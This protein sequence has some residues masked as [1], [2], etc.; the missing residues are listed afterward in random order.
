[1]SPSNDD[2][3]NVQSERW[4]PSLCVQSATDATTAK[5]AHFRPVIRQST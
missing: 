2:V 3:H 4:N 5:E 1:M